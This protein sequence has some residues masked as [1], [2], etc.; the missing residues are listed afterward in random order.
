MPPNGVRLTLQIIFIPT[1]TIWTVSLS[2]HFPDIPTIPSPPPPSP[3]RQSPM[4]RGG[5]RISRSPQRYHRSGAQANPVGSPDFNL[6][7]QRTT[8]D[9]SYSSTSRMDRS[10]G[11][12]RRFRYIRR[13]L[14]LNPPLNSHRTDPSTQSYSGY[15]ILPRPIHTPPRTQISRDSGRHVRFSSPQLSNQSRHR[16]RR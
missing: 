14:F 12:L 15:P 8:P 1:P 6:N 5:N 9:S 13:I 10:P 11:R 7:R 16:H 2:E 4:L 3:L